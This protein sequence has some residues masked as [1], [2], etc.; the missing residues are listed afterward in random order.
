MSDKRD[1][2]LDL[3]ASCG[4]THAGDNTYSIDEYDLVRVMERV[5][6]PPPQSM[7]VTPLSAYEQAALIILGLTPASLPDAKRVELRQDGKYV[8][9]YTTHPE[10]LVRVENGELVLLRS[11]VYCVDTIDYTNLRALVDKLHKYRADYFV[12]RPFSAN[13]ARAAEHFIDWVRNGNKPTYCCAQTWDDLMLAIRSCAYNTGLR[14][15]F[16]VHRVKLSRIP[17][18]LKL[19]IEV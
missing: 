4:F 7:T 16:G 19:Y 6:K 15:T 14:R 10:L 11:S 13:A 8:E 18:T 3:A 2:L 17:N 5:D 9:L 1:T 12:C